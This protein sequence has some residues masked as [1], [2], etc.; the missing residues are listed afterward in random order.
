MNQK[1]HCNPLLFQTIVKVLMRQLYMMLHIQTKEN[2][3]TLPTNRE[4]LL[5]FF[6][7]TNQTISKATSITVT[8]LYGSKNRFYTKILRGRLKEPLKIAFYYSLNTCLRITLAQLGNIQ[9]KLP[10]QT[11]LLILR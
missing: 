4:I 1:F 7:L 6:G 9:K 2:I 5:I 11:V 10:S 8:L 3:T